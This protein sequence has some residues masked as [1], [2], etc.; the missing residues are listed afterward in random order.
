[1]IRLYGTVQG[2]GSY[3]RVTAGIRGAIERAGKL[4]GFVPID[5]YDPEER[6]P[7]WNA[8]I[9]VYIGQPAGVS[10]VKQ[11]GNHA[12]RLLLLPPNS[13]WM[14]LELLLHADKYATHLIA[15]SAWA[16]YVQKECIRQTMLNL[17]TTLWRHGVD[18]GFAPDTARHAELVREYDKG[19][20]RVLHMSSSEQE[21]KGTKELLLAW[22]LAVWEGRLGELP[23]LTLVLI[24]NSWREYAEKAARGDQK[25]LDTL[26]WS[27]SRI[28]LPVVAMANLYRQHHA[29]CQPSR[30]E[31]FGLVPLEALACGVPVM[32]TACTGHAEHV[33]AENPGT[34]VVPTGPD[35]PVDDGPGAMAPTVDVD[36]LACAL[37]EVYDQWKTY[38]AN[39][40]VLGSQ[41]VREQ[42][43]WDRVTADWL[44][45]DGVL[46]VTHGPEPVRE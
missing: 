21:R 16:E 3:A 42:W 14:P 2:H 43:S 18:P 37:G 7:G 29:V 35:A 32:A 17:G 9:G 38:A 28:D 39:A 23:Q 1:V 15:P 8:P 30:G 6:Y 46:E 25:L 44:E 27:H 45:R 33:T 40:Q 24:E 22:A 34:V 19:T 11:I 10:I 26:C 12:R 41:A 5:A 13:N 20:F 36:H 31:G 4:S